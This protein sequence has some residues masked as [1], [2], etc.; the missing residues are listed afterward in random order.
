MKRAWAHKVRRIKEERERYVSSGDARSLAALPAG[1]LVGDTMVV[2]VLAGY[3]S[4]DT[5][6]YSTAALQTKLFDNASGT[7]TEYWS[8]V[9][10][11]NLTM[12][13]SIIGW[14][15][16]SNSNSYYVGLENGT[17]P[18]TDRTGEMIKELLDAN[19]GSIDFGQF[20][21]DGPDGV[22]NSGDDDGFVDFVTILHSRE[23]AECNASLN[24]MWS[25][26]WIYSRWNVSNG[27]PYS[28]NDVSNAPG[29]ATI[30]VDDYAVVPAYNCGGVSMID[31]GVF[32]HE[33]GHAFG[34]PDLYDTRD[35]T[36]EG[37]GHWGLMGS[38]NWNTPSSPA[39]PCAWTRKEL[40]WLVPTDVDWT[41]AST[42]IP[43]INSNPAALRLAMTDDRFRRTTTCAIDGSYSLYCGLTAAEAV[44]RGWVDTGPGYGSSWTETVSHTFAYDGAGSVSF[45]Y[46]FAYD[47]EVT[48]DFAYA[49]IDVEGAET[50]LATYTGTGSGTANI[51]LDSHLSGLAAGG[52]YTIKFRVETDF[53]FGNDDGDYPSTCGAIVVDN[54]SV[55]GGGES[56]TADFEAFSDGWFQSPAH[57][58]PDEYW[59]IENRRKV[60]YDQNLLEEGLLIFHVDENVL[61]SP[62]QGNSGGE[63]G[64]IVR[65]LVLEEAD[66]LFNLNVGTTNRGQ[67][68]DPYPGTNDNRNFTGATI[69]GAVTNSGRTTVISATGISD[70]MSTM[71]ANLRGGDEGPTAVSL[72]PTAV[73]NDQT[74]TSVVITG[75]FIKPGATFAF[76]R[77]GGSFGADTS[78][79]VDAVR[80]EGEFNAYGRNGGMWDLV[81]TNPDGQSATL[82]DALMVNQ[83]ITAAKL[84]S[85]SISV[86]RNQV[87]LWYVLFDVEQGEK[88]RLYRADP[89]GF[90]WILLS[91]DLQ[92][93]ESGGYFYLDDDVEPGRTYQYLLESRTLDGGTIELHRG[94]ATTAAY[95][96]SLE[97][98]VPNPF[99]PT[100][101]IRYYVPSKMDAFLEIH[102]VAGRKV[103]RLVSGAVG[104]G[105]QEV[106]WDGTDIN[107]ASVAS[108]MY[109]YRL[110]AGSR[111]L[112]RKMM[113]LK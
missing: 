29:V 96:L 110:R 32:C 78:R 73:D 47:L 70:A 66:G 31:I 18:L 79:W 83:M 21:N 27:L 82:V 12:T 63:T 2:P 34:L 23:G 45:S 11:G 10:Y 75:D 30:Q 54:I 95:A 97:Q 76:H 68:S 90:D 53:S 102:D 71:S 36:K 49:V 16:L 44:N 15:A 56:Y 37:I 85:A 98:N 88:I 17:N 62:G 74:T 105:W 9:S 24:N 109:V 7:V 8:E 107:G 111:V 61:D 59:L 46:D 101:T 52:F 20:D 14:T 99:N 65:G 58:S 25:H 84:V 38:G 55:S 80:L 113:L 28:T 19:D 89:G 1:L 26:R 69:P 5:A 93:E 72:V 40:G 51:P 57:N 4:D 103:A 91:D 6:P 100:T 3:F 64:S 94:R 35:D 13:G 81:V 108:G 43:A 48:Y 33:F 60:G 104:P 67:A 39:H 106:H 112:T 41:E 87:Q 92:K 50:V 86:V 77:G 22:P 42:P